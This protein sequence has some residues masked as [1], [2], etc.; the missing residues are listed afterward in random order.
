MYEMTGNM[1]LFEFPNRFMAEQILQGE[2]RW[3]KFK[4]HLEWWNHTAGCIPNSQI[5]ETCWIRAM[6]IP[7]HLWSQKIFKE[8]GD[9][10]GGWLATEEETDLKNH[11]KW[12]RIKIAGDGRKTPNE[13]GIERDG[14][15]FFIPIWAESQTRYELKTQENEQCFEIERYLNNQVGCTLWQNTDKGK[16]SGQ[17]AQGSSSMN[18]SS[19][20]TNNELKSYDSDLAAQVIFND[21]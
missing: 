7:L 3:K 15:K 5:E 6:G 4:L 19:K 21:L 20:V 1:F 14:I 18:Q 17:L 11:L 16:A 10:C 13:V 8:I 2:W 9:I 12:A